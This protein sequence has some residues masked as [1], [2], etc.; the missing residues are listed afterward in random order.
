M[1]ELEKATL[2]IDYFN[3]LHK[4]IDFIY[5]INRYKFN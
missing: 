4:I 5:W 1:I 3:L 2:K